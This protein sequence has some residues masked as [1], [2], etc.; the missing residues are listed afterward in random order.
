MENHGGKLASTL[1]STVY[2]ICVHASVP[3]NRLREMVDECGSNRVACVDHT[4]IHRYVEA[5]RF[6]YPGPQ[7][8]CGALDPHVSSQPIVLIEEDD[9]DVVVLDT[10][11]LRW[12][13]L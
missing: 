11:D 3:K 13:L 8:L 6:V 1:D 5:K 4:W 7:F 9:D 10:H 12:T 2:I